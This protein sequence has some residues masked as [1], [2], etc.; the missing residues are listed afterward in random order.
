[1]VYESGIARRSLK[2]WLWRNLT[3]TSFLE[4]RPAG[5]SSVTVSPPNV[6]IGVCV[7]MM[8]LV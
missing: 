1:M 7:V 4:H 5:K 8:M 2:A 3:H 6:A